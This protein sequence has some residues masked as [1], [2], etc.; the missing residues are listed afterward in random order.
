MQQA[1]CQVEAVGVP[2]ALQPDVDGLAGGGS[3]DK[4]MGLWNTTAGIADGVCHDCREGGSPNL[5]KFLR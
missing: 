4:R 3:R 1:V 2:A 5:P